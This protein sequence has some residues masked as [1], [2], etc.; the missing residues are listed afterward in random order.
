M[1]TG[2]PTRY[3]AEYAEQ[4]E[5]LC[6]LGAT[7]KDLAGF[8]GVSEQTI[9]AWKKKHPSFLES[10]NRFKRVADDE[11]ERSLFQRANGYS[12][13]ETKV[14]NNNGEIV[15]HEV[16]RHYPPDATSMIFWLKNRKPADWRDTKDLNHN[17]EGVTDDELRAIAEGVK[18]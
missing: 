9:N 8:F 1:A 18:K 17:F 16:T 11:V 10:L 14:F 3:R 4:A 5:T 2:R 12:H 15:T 6:R 7:D 13:P